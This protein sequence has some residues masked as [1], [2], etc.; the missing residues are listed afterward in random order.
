MRP[1][2]VKL[3]INYVLGITEYHTIEEDKLK[4]YNDYVTTTVKV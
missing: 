3:E 4:E 2:Y 1:N